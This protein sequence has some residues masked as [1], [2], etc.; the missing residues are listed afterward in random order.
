MKLPKQLKLR[1]YIHV[2]DKG[3]PF[4]GSS[5]CTLTLYV[6][7]E[8]NTFLLLVFASHGNHTQAT[9]VGEYYMKVCEGE[10]GREGGVGKL[11]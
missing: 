9:A 10:V 1:T 2:G 11:R 7:P 5:R 3:V 4:T 8:V 6:V